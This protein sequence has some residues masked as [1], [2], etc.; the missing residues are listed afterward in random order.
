M[1]YSYDRRVAKGAKL[2]PSTRRKANGALVK[3][4]LDGNGRFR[5]VG[6]GLSKAFD[7]LATFGIEPDETLNAHLFTGDEGRRTLEL[8]FTNQEDSFSP[9]NV[10][11]SVLVFSWYTH[12]QD[13]IEVLA[14]LS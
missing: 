12:D 13:R 7:V 2:D 10:S 3:A 1:T 14:Y 9:T 8:A 11:N 4:G 5:S 6:Q